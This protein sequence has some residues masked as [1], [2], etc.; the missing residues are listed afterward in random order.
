MP[1]HRLT[2]LLILSHLDLLCNVFCLL[3][4]HL[5]D[6]DAFSGPIPRLIFLLLP[7]MCPDV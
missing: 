7:L 3:T 5:H 2:S 6:P 4:L 1:A